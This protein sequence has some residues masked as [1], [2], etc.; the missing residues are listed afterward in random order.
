MIIRELLVSKYSKGKNR[1][2]DSNITQAK[3]KDPLVNSEEKTKTYFQLDSLIEHLKVY[4]DELRGSRVPVYERS[5]IR[6][7]QERKKMLEELR[8]SPVNGKI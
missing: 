1:L 6:T 3:T 4:R 2:T 8:N 7:Q 5:F